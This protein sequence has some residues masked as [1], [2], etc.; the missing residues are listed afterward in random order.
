M[1]NIFFFCML[2]AF[3]F[4]SC[5]SSKV[6]SLVHQSEKLK[7]ERLT[8]HSFRHTSYLQT[9][10]VG[11]VGCNGMIVIEGDEA[12]VFDT[13]SYNEDSKELI[14]WIQTAMKA[15]ITAVVATHFHI[16]CLGGLQAFHEEG[17]ASYANTETIALAKADGRTAPLNGFSGLKKITSW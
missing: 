5:K 7:I 3:S 6:P 12:I 9:K 8:K 13:P 4:Q 17:V 15:K 2:I 10:S 1:K 11:K 14:D 16:D